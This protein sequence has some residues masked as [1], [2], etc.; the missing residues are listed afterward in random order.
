MQNASESLGFC[1]YDTQTIGVTAGL[2]KDHMADVILHEIIH[3]L[4][5]AMGLKEDSDEENVAHRI[6]T[7]ICTVFKSNPK[8]FKWWSELL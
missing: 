5:F 8:F 2:A 4:Y 7:G 1:D 6:A 3:A